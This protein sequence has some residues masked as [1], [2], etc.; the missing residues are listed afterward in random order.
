MVLTGCNLI[1][2][3]PPGAGKGTQAKGVSEKLGIAHI[4]CGRVV[5]DEVS[6]KTEFGRK[7]E[8]YMDAGRLVPDE[9][10]IG[11]ML[12]RI[13]EPGCDG[14]Y[15]LDGFPRTLQQARG[16][17][18]F[19]SGKGKRLD[20]ILSLA[21]DEDTAVRRL[22]SRR[23]CPACGSVFNVLT[24]PPKMDGICD[25]CAGELVQRT[26]DKPETIIE[27]LKVYEAETAPVKEYYRNAEGYMEFDSSGDPGVVMEEI[28]TAIREGGRCG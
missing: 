24:A 25:N 9:L 17:D 28:V 22:S 14:G 13:G 2:L 27:R 5:R 8:E 3:G 7:A 19:L 4:D 23:Y 18:E 6:G 12:K 21:I 11:M 26:D 15:L 10:I 16:L 1:I 20:Y